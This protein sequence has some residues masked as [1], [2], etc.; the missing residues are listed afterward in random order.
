MQI[1]ILTIYINLLC[2]KPEAIERFIKDGTVKI[3]VN[4]IDTGNPDIIYHVF[5]CLANL[6]VEDSVDIRPILVS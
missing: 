5:W 3:M 1:K 6:L 4:L 2:S